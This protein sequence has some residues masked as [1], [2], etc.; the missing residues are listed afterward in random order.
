VLFTVCK[1]VLI[2]PVLIFPLACK[3]LFAFPVSNRSWCRACFYF[4]EKRKFLFLLNYARVTD[5]LPQIC[6]LHRASTLPAAE[7]NSMVKWKAVILIL[8]TL[9]RVYSKREG[10]LNIKI[11]KKL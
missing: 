7:Q 5:C 2:V 3:H 9:C 4:Q 10:P 1:N 6:Q 11:M 8:T